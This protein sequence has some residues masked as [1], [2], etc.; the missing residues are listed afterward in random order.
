MSDEITTEKVS[1]D[2]F[3]AWSKKN[4]DAVNLPT[5]VAVGETWRITHEDGDHSDIEIVA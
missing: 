5:E 4:S 2:K 3:Q 1:V